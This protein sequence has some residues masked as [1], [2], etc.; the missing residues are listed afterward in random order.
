[1]VAVA[2]LVGAGAYAL[3]RLAPRA[4]SG[5]VS[6]RDLTGP[7]D[8]A[9]YGV[10][11]ADRELGLRWSATAEDLLGGAGVT[12]PRIR[13]I[14]EP[15][16]PTEAAPAPDGPGPGAGT[17][18]SS[19]AAPDPGTTVASSGT[20]TD[21]PVLALA[22]GVPGA[23]DK[24]A[25][26]A[27]LAR[28]DVVSG[29]ILWRGPML[30]DVPECA[31][32][33][34][35]V[36]CVDRTADAGQVVILDPRDGHE[37]ARAAVAGRPA[38]V[39]VAGDTTYVVAATPDGASDAGSVRVDVQRIGAD[40]AVRWTHS[41]RAPAGSMPGPV[42]VSGDAVVVTGVAVGRQEYVVAASDGALADGR[43][44]G[45]A[46]PPVGALQPVATGPDAWSAGDGPALVGAPARLSARDGRTQVPLL[47]DSFGRGPAGGELLAYADA[48]NPTPLWTL[49]AARPLAACGGRLIVGLA[50]SSTS[51]G[52]GSGVL[53]S[54][55][56]AALE[57]RTGVVAW[58]APLDGQVPASAACT[59]TNVVVGGRGGS[60][61]VTALR[62][63]TGAVSWSSAPTG[64][65]PSD[66]EPARAVAR[67]D[68]LLVVS[69]LS[70]SAR[71]DCLG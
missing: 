18:G 63:D 12:A 17:G 43:R 34:R 24:A 58:R 13:I 50:G 36:A 62:L 69:R 46:L 35:V 15:G 31:A 59:A 55:E 25:A 20:A 53:S 57:P 10:L 44:T 66:A 23:G 21:A 6:A 4:E 54:A 2:A 71:L 5:V 11:R 52:S 32:S 64:L 33:A 56:I 28:V 9:A 40:G 29:T 37:I 22:S 41:E 70:G 60:G 68:R 16:A 51:G 30:G 65:A 61:S 19:S 49:P 7:G 45:A 47:A 67:G 1:M 48:A 42:V 8:T 39:A 38:R 27:R 14:D 3:P 26:T